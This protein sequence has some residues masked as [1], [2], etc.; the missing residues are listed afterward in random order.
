MSTE[1]GHTLTEFIERL[2]GL[3]DDLR[4]AR[5]AR[6]SMRDIELCRSAIDDLYDE[7]AE[8]GYTGYDVISFRRERDGCSQCDDIAY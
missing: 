1:P 7:A 6:M 8:W 2:D 5:E 4:N 3:Y